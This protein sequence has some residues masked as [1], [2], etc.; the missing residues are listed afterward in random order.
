MWHHTRIRR[1]LRAFK[2][3]DSESM[4]AHK[5]D[6]SRVQRTQSSVRAVSRGESSR[7]CAG[8]QVFGDFSA[9]RILQPADE[10]HLVNVDA[11][12]GINAKQ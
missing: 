7:P 11:E 3:I 5:F 12:T 4:L 9:G 8:H 6:A 1:T 10:C 2:K